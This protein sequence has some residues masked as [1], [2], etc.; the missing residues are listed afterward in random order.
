MSAR[1]PGRRRQH[2]SLLPTTHQLLDAGFLLALLTAAL[3][4]LASTYTGL[5]FAVVG[6]VGMVVAILLGHVASTYRWPAVAPVLLATLVFFL[7]GGALCLRT[8][9]AVL[10]T[11]RSFG[12]LTEQVIFGWKDLLTTLPPVDGDGALLV[13][14]WVLGLAAGTLGALLT[15]VSHGP[16]WLRAVLPLTAPVLLL[17][18]VILLGVRSP[19]SLMTQGVAVAALGLTWLVVRA[20]RTGTA[21]VAGSGRTTRLLVGAALL[22]VAGAAA[23]PVGTW[24]AGGDD[25]D[26]ERVI[27]RTYVEPPFDV[28]QYPSPLASFRRYVEMP[29]PDGVN[30]YDTVLFTAEGA[31]AGTRVRIA[32]LDQYDGVVWGASDNAFPGTVDDTFQRVGSTLDNPVEGTP[33]D[34][35]VT[36]DEGYGGVWLPTVGA[37]QSIEFETDADRYQES[38]RY[39]LDSSTG[40]VPTGLSAGDRYTFTAV[41]PPDE[42]TPASVPSGQVGTAAA[43]A[44]FLD[45]PAATWTEGVTDPMGRVFAIADHLRTEGK[46]SDG[47]IAR[48]KIYRPGHFA[49]RLDRFFVNAPIMVGNDEQYAAVMALMANKVGVPARVVMGAT[50]PEGGVVR[51]SDVAAWV[52]LRVGDGSW[53]VLPTEAFMDTDRPANQQTQTEEQLSGLVISP[54]AQVPPPSTIDEQTDAEITARKVQRPAKKDQDG[55]AAGSAWLGAV[56]VYGGG[57]LLAILLVVGAILGAKLLRRSR[58]RSTRQTSRRFVG[59]WHELVDHA[60]DL[61]QPVPVRGITRREQSLLITLPEAPSLA[62]ALARRA[63][64]S[65]FGPAPPAADDAERFWAEVTSARQALSASVSRRR[66]VLGALSLRTFWHR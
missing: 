58:R 51:G 9:D 45:A 44:P 13:L 66:R 57:P 41:V 20:Q 34:V 61:G 31:P 19:H 49:S 11:P 17:A 22:A 64:A 12:L 30:L 29:K 39:N 14:P 26:R 65:V 15:R 2:P 8:E 5:G 25:A 40:V 1:R 3:L 63:D 56:L 18:A 28:G 36:L 42:V 52:E 4:G 35:R 23:A 16:S 62:P 10:P 46:Y 55:A 43:A 53:R 59:A 50:L 60:R 48:E 27:L 32:T 37:L 24:A 21:V 54:P 33:V 47:V 6:F 38:F 7:L